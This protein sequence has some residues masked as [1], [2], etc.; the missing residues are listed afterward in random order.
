MDQAA[1]G[2][3][4][5]D[6]QDMLK[7]MSDCVQSMQEQMNRSKI[8][9]FAEMHRD[10]VPQFS[11]EEVRSATQF[12]DTA[13]DAMQSIIDGFK[14]ESLKK[15]DDDNIKM[16]QEKCRESARKMVLLFGDSS[17]KFQGDSMKGQMVS[18]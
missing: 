11:P 16:M 9:L 2:I 12:L 10:P 15:A 3:A 4:S 17:R 5:F 18:I 8:A 1:T 7:P 14:A 6:V 13:K